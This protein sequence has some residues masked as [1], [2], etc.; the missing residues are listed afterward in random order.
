LLAH[1]S[2]SG[3]EKWADHFGKE[4]KTKVTRGKV[5]TTSKQFLRPSTTTTG[6]NEQTST[7]FLHKYQMENFMRSGQTQDHNNNKVTLGLKDGE[8]YFAYDNSVIPQK[9]MPAWF[10]LMSSL[11][12]K[13]VGGLYSIT[14]QPT[15]LNIQAS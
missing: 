3:A 7:E 11:M 1:A 14:L 12:N 15:P 5:D 8:C 9:P 13:D 10:A 6:T 2:A 4:H